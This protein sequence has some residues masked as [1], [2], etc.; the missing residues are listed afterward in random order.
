MNPRATSSSVAPPF[1]NPGGMEGWVNLGL[2]TQ[3]GIEPGATG[4]EAD[5]TALDYKVKQ[6]NP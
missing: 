2:V 6:S 4:Y 5:I 3:P 1:T